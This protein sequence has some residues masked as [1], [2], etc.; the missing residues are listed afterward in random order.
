MMM[1]FMKRKGLYIVIG[2]LLIFNILLGVYNFFSLK[3]R[4]IR[5][6][7][8]EPDVAPSVMMD[9]QTFYNSL[10]PDFTKKA[11]DGRDIHL[12][13]LK[14]NLIILRFSRF[15]LEELP[16][17]LYLEHLAN[18][19]K[20]NGVSLIFINSL[21]KHYAESISKYIHLESPVIED[22]GMLSSSF[23]ASP[24]ETIIIGR[25]FRIKFKYRIADNRTI[26]NQVIRFAF[27][28]KSPPLLNDNELASSIRKL[29]FKD[30]RERKVLNIE[31][32]I[33][34]EKETIL[35]LFISSCMSCPE[36]RRIRLLKEIE[37]KA[38]SKVKILILFGKGNG[39]EMIKDWAERMEL[40]SSISVG[41][42]ER[43]LREEEYLRLFHF[44]IDPRIIILDR[45]GE[46]IYS[47]KEGD[48]R[49]MSP[50]FILRK[51]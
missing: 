20:N 42:I 39:L 26:Y 2:F 16:Y 37:G 18:R 29:K 35:N 49:T 6:F 4:D 43:G 41:V 7:I 36:G 30:V 5:T 19:F 47:E 32:I 44:G 12:S 23:Q 38:S 31:D 27:D 34:K 48:E 22:D 15:Y 45:K 11:V 24:Y 25:D 1:G 3:R 17:L 10:S 40:G 50:E 9:K 21:G 51:L 33:K 14:G 8:R 28:E 13:T 46:I